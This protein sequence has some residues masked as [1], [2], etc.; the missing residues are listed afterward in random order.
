MTRI[1]LVGLGAAGLLV[2]GGCQHS[3]EAA[4]PTPAAVALSRSGRGAEVS[5][6]ERGRKI[7]TT[8]CTECHVARPIA[9]YSVEQWHY[10]VKIMSPRAGLQPPDQAAL[11]T[12]LIA[13]RATLPPG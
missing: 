8:S 5:T 12:Y 2:L 9:H 4:F 1:S 6:L 7:Y 11:E 13:A 10:F 3:P